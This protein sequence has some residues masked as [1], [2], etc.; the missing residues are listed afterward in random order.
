MK[1]HRFRI[2]KDS[3]CAIGRRGWQRNWEK[4]KPSMIQR[5]LGVCALGCLVLALS[6]CRRNSDLHGGTP[7]PVAQKVLAAAR[8]QPLH[9]CPDAPYHKLQA[10]DPATGHHRVFLRWSSS[11]SAGT[12]GSKA[13]G[14]CLYR[15][16]E[17]G[18]AKDCPTK[19]PKCEQINVVPVR[20]TRCVDELVKDD[21]TYYYVA[22]AITSSETS[23]TSEEAIAEVPGAGKQNP[24]PLDASSY[25]A[26]RIPKIQP[27]HNLTR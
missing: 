14:Y 20:D 19:Y 17:P 7:T 12:A 11:T 1:F 25:P 27:P 9:D 18:R 3:L 22:L 8:Q 26:C 16:Q 6:S 24:P 21:T 2:R 13:L 15:T 4:P 5:R 23:T 10:K